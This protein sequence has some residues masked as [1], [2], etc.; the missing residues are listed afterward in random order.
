MAA[1]YESK[2]KLGYSDYDLS[3]TVDH[4]ICEFYAQDK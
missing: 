3:D 4:S 2:A 1:I